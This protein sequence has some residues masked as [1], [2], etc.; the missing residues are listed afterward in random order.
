MDEQIR[1]KYANDLLD[2]PV[3]LEA[4]EQIQVGINRELEDPKIKPDDSFRLALLRQ[5]C[6]KVITHIT[7]VAN[8]P[9]VT[10]FNA[11]QK[12]RKFF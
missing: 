3:F 4:M 7:S 8:S 6:A 12:Q 11:R 1:A 10:E 9:K 2:N 5:A